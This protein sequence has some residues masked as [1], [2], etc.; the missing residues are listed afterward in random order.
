M[1]MY[2]TSTEELTTTG[3]KCSRRKAQQA[4]HAFMSCQILWRL[5]SGLAHGNA[6]D[7]RSV[8]ENSRV[9]TS[10]RRLMIP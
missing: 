1:G 9:L 7:E 5:Y 3:E 6:E 8:S 10:E 4:H 2:P